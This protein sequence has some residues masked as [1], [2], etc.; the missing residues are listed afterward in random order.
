VNRSTQ[1]RY[2]RIPFAAVLVILA[3]GIAGIAAEREKP[4][5]FA[6]EA[7]TGVNELPT[8]PI[9]LVRREIYVPSPRPGV[10]PVV[11]FQY[12]G[13]GLRL[14]EFRFEQGKSDL[15]EKG[16]AR[17]SDDNGRNWTPFVPPDTGSGPLRQNENSVAVASWAIQFDPVS[18]RTIE[19]VF[20]RVFLGEPSDILKKYWKGE[21]KFYDHMTYRLSADDGRTWTKQRPMVYESGAQFDPNNWANP[22][23]LPS[24][25]MYG[26]YDIT[27]LRNGQI[28]YPASIRVAYQDDEEDLKVCANVPKYTA[29]VPGYVGGVSCFLGKWNES[30]EDYEWTHSKPVFVARRISTRGLSEPVIAEL[31]DG[32][33][34]LEMRG[35][36]AGLDPLKYPGRKWMS[37]SK[38]GGKNWSAVT[39]LRYD[40]G[41]QFYAPSTLAKFIRSRKTGALYWVGNISRGPAKGNLPRYPLYIAEV[42]EK[43]PALKKSTLTVIDDRSP[44]DTKAVQFSNFSLNENRETLDLEIY[45]SRF[46]ENKGHVFSAN[47]YKYTLVLR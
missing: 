8:A 46:G 33:L 34:L 37:L 43:I 12:L 3:G 1:R 7:R 17:F 26:S 14:R 30:K 11:R 40:T 2:G 25:E 5:E 39:D 24:N 29:P 15:T 22:A 19:M 27:V 38:D 41:E 16:M 44:E 6:S 20:Q 45:L 9:C 35:S 47:A 31:K 21:K 10:S 32:T 18:R 28:A 36:N 42:D 23:Y 4:S 13:D